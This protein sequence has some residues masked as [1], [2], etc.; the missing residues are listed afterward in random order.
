MTT[1]DTLVR[2]ATTVQNTTGMTPDYAEIKKKQKVTW[3]SGDYSVVGSTLNIVGERLVETMNIGP[4][5]LVL[6]VAAGNGNATLAAAR[7]YA[8][9]IST[10]YVLELLEDGRAR[11]M[12]DRLMAS[13]QQADAEDLPF[14]DDSFD[15]VVST[16]GVM[17]TPNQDKAA[18][19][20]MRVCRPGGLVGMANWTPDSFIGALFRTI[21]KYAPPPAGVRAPAMWGTEEHVANLLS[22][23]MAKLEA[24]TCTFVFRYRSI[25]HWIEVFRDYYGP[26]HMVFQNLSKERQEEL[27]ADMTALAESFNE[28]TDGAMAVPATYL[29]VVATKRG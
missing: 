5:Q 27:V 9:V 25:A 29:E 23:E 7:R 11:V 4:G 15:A 24:T 2:A 14:P 21:G 1:T 18:A 19:E 8:D 3:A 22:P 26:T 28:A 16:F 17:F 13:F 6:D 10:D 12:A 20:M